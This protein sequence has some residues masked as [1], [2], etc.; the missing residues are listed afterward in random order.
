[1]KKG[2]N[3]VERETV[4]LWGGWFLGRW[5]MGGAGLWVCREPFHVQ[6]Y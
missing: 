5:L 6:F 4:R 2:W 3:G 1:V